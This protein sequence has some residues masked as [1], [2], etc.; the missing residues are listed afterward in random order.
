MAVRHVRHRACSSSKKV[1]CC[2]MP[3]LHDHGAAALLR[4]KCRGHVDG[5]V[6]RTNKDQLGPSNQAR[7]PDLIYGPSP[8]HLQHQTGIVKTQPPLL[9]CCIHACIQP[10]A[11]LDSTDS[12]SRQ[13]FKMCPTCPS[14]QTAYTSSSF[15]IRVYC[16]ISCR[17]CT[18]TVGQRRT[19]GAL[20]MEC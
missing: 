19:R 13:I 11:A 7:P 15:L 4:A 14:R 8:P 3:S 20:R 17:Y 5:R 18:G 9:L 16:E 6:W 12:D 1:C 2:C 10:A